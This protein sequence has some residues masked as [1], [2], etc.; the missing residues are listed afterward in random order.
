MQEICTSLGGR[1]PCYAIV[2]QW[3]LT[4]DHIPIEGGFGAQLTKDPHDHFRLFIS[5]IMA[6]S[7]STV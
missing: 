7:P 6:D 3:P 5:V 4:A 1:L 2:N